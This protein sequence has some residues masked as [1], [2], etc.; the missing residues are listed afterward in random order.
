MPNP[1]DLIDWK[2]VASLSAAISQRKAAVTR[3]CTK[4]AKL[5]ARPYNFLSPNQIEKA[6]NELEQAFDLLQNI[7]YRI[8]DISPEPVPD[9][10]KALEDYEAKYEKALD[11]L[12]SYI[13]DNSRSNQSQTSQATSNAPVSVDKILF[14][15]PLLRSATPEEF[16]LWRSTFEHFITSGS[17]GKAPPTNPA[18]IP[19]SLPE[20]GATKIHVTENQWHH[21]SGPVPTVA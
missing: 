7:T 21:P 9:D 6:Q 5:V 20:S 18:N 3:A 15:D 14:P 2:S 4:V 19:L 1:E 11:K 8:S 13:D 12:D 16:R 10:L 17:V